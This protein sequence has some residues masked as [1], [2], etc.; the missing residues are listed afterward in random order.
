[1]IVAEY[2]RAAPKA[3]LHLHL[4]GAVRPAT[5]LDLARRHHVAL[6]VDSLSDFR[7]WFR[8]RDFPHFAAVNAVLRAC[9][10]ELADLERV[11]H[12]LG[13]DLADQHVRYAEVSFTPGPEVW[14]G[15]H[16]HDFLLG[17]TRGREHSL[18]TSGVEI[19]FIFDIPR[20]TARLYPEMDLIDFATHAAID[21]KHDGVV[22][23]GLSGTELGNPPEPF[24]AWFEQALAAGLHSAPH[25][26]ETDGPA[27]VW[28]ALRALGA[29]RLGHGVRA[30]EDPALVAF[31]AAHAIPLEVCPTSNLRL[32]VY[33]S[34][35][36]H[37]LAA[38]HAAGVP[39]TINTDTPAIFGTTI[40]AELN[41]LPTHFGLDV[42]GIDEIILNGARASFLPPERKAAL[43]SAFQ[44]ELALLK[45]AHL[46]S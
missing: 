1:V 12:E 5:L 29:E 42:A 7:E 20:R 43:V 4:Q 27:S 10:V 26:G 15:R 32:G 44:A 6:P 28:G 45:E 38:L 2:I 33:A 37:P 17:L 25:A 46:R 21:G 11:V 9:L 19:N 13:A 18:R 41:F 22:G 8:F 14:S 30:A 39:I 23:L 40:S 3:E 24:A 31:L 34:L 16:R 36:D 35:D